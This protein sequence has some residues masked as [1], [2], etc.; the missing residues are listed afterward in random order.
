M[1]IEINRNACIGCGMCISTDTENFDYDKEGYAVAKN[2]NI[3]DL[4]MDAKNYCPV[5]AISIIN[6]EEKPQE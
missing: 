6:E 1:K 2:N 5:D 4:T 3:T